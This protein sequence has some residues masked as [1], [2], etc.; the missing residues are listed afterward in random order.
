MYLLLNWYF[1]CCGI[2]AFGWN[3]VHMAELARVAPPRLLGEVTSA[4]NLF[5]FLGSVGGPLGFT[6]VVGWSGSYALAFALAA[7]QLAVF[8]LVSLALLRRAARS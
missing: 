8:A 1:W 4:A 6:L 3:G 5:G 7:G 2:T